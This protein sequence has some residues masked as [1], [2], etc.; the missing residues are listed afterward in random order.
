MGKNI[1]AEFS[2]YIYDISI[3]YNTDKRNILTNYFNYIVRK[4]PECA[5]PEFLNTAEFITHSTDAELEDVLKFCYYH[6]H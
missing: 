4:M 5:T 1:F 6:L 3:R 2:A